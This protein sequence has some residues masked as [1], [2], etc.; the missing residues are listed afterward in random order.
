MC[1]GNKIISIGNNPIARQ[2]L[3]ICSALAVTTKLSTSVVMSLAVIF[4]LLGSNVAVSLIRNKVPSSIRIIVQLTIIASLVIITD[5][6]LKAFVFDISKELTVFVG[7]IITNCIIMGRA[8]A[9]AMQNPVK[10]SALDALGNGFGYSIVLLAVAFMRELFGSGKLFGFT[11]LQPVTEG[12]WYVP[13]GLMVLAPAAFFLIGIF[14]WAVRAWK[15]EQ[16]EEEFHVGALLELGNE[17]S[18]R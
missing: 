7:L 9:F 16:V 14:I 6:V 15:P 11:V 2:V 5:Q 1:H 17:G 4:V 8:E 13:N 12:G 10:K 3:G 18:L